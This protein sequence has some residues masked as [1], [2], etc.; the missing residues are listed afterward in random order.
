MTGRLL[1]T[2]WRPVRGQWS[3]IRHWVKR[4][5]PRTARCLI[6][7]HKAQRSDEKLKRFQPTISRSGRQPGPG[8]G[9]VSFHGLVGRGAQGVPC[10]LVGPLLRT[11]LHPAPG[12]EARTG[13][14]SAA[15]SGA[16]F[17]VDHI[18]PSFHG[19]PGETCISWLLCIL[20]D[21][22]KRRH[23][24]ILPEG[25]RLAVRRL[26]ENKEVA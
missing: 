24:N 25:I 8:S 12:S 23:F 21:G 3:C 1:R 22:C 9:A 10:P 7:G 13:T 17:V 11:E 16:N 4:K 5:L 14:G 26:A 20:C 15:G 2:L 18:I 19:G 6:S